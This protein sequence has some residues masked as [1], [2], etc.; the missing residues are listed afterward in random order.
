LFLRPGFRRSVHLYVLAWL[1]I[2]ALVWAAHHV[3]IRPKP[4]NERRPVAPWV[5]FIIGAINMSVF[6]IGVFALPEYGAPP[7]IVTML[8]LTLLDA[9]SLWLLWRWSGYWRG[10]DDRHRLALVAGLLAFFV[11]FC[12]AKDFESWRGSSVVGILAVLGLWG[13]GRT[14]RRR[15]GINREE[16][17][18]TMV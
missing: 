13:L 1:T 14:V 2:L 3:A 10:W 12:F 4:E 7:L 17:P 15:I 6:F 5:F 18:D 16:Q 9:I 11:F 8:S